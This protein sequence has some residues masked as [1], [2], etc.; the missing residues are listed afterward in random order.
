[1]YTLIERRLTMKTLKTRVLAFRMTESEYRKIKKAAKEEN[2]SISNWLRI[3]VS[4]VV[5]EK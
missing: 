1:M 2:R 5:G 3:I 4:L